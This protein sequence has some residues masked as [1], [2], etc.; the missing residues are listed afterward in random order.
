MQEIQEAT[1]SEPLT[2]EEEYAM[3]GTWRDDGD[4]LTFII[5]RPFDL[6]QDKATVAPQDRHHAVSIDRAEARLEHDIDAMVGDVNLFISNLH[7]EDEDHFRR[8]NA[9]AR[10]VDTTKLV[11]VVVGELELM[12]A[13][14][15]QQR[16]GYG[17]AALVLFLNYIMCNE[18]QILEEFS[19]D[20]GPR[21]ARTG[22]SSPPLQFDFF[23]VKIGSANHRSLALFEGLGFRM[24]SAQP[25]YFGE[26]ELRLGR[27]EA[28]NFV[29]DGTADRDGEMGRK[30]L[31][32]DYDESTYRCACDAV[33]NPVIED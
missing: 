25:N 11:H 21:A 16:K 3:Q 5:C 12:I 6:D 24:T 13:E 33:A 4:K 22:S 19:R 29:V 9:I 26:Y 2:L 14:R 23:S 32:L 8:D 7:I 15:S 10:L 1:A 28:E 30:T 17:K 20:A 18:Q 27:D 31:R